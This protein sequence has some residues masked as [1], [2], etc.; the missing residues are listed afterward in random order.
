MS[1]NARALHPAHYT[2][3]FP[4]LIFARI[5][6][7][8]PEPLPDWIFSGKNFVRE[9]GRSP[10]REEVEVSQFIEDAPAHERRMHRRRSGRRHYFCVG[11][12]VADPAVGS[13]LAFPQN[14]R[15]ASGNSEA[16]W[17]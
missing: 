7:I 1:S 12:E 16:D 15:S 17:S 14:I 5:G 9:A 3:D 11:G 4:H 6:R 8:H 2:D 10:S 13:G